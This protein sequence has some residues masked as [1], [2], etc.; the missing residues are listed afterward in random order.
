MD[1]ILIN[2]SKLKI[3]LTR[4]DMASYSLTCDNIDYDNTETRRAFWDIL[5]AAKHKTGFDAA[6]DRIFIQIYP[7]K[8]GGCE[9]YVTKLMQQN[10]S[11]FQNGSVS[12]SLKPPSE[13]IRDIYRFNEINDLISACVRMCESGYRGQSSVWCD[14]SGTKKYYLILEYKCGNYDLLCEYGGKCTS[15]FYT[16]ITEHCKNIRLGDAVNVMAALK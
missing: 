15:G 4:D 11:E 10:G 3:M 9:M 6:T 8:A 16:Y 13:Y 14:E 7:S 5:D 2:N 1:L 12:F